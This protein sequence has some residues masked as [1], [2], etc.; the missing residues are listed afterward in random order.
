MLYRP[1]L[2]FAVVAVQQ[3][4]PNVVRSQIATGE[5]RWY[6][7]RCY[8]APNDTLTIES[9]VATIKERPWGAELLVEGDFNI[10]LS[11]PE[12]DRRGEDIAVALATE[13]L[14]DMS[15]HFLPRRRSWCRDGRM[16]SIIWE[17]REVRSCTDY[18]LGTD[19][20]IF[21]NVYVWDPQA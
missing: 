2:H 8:L 14:E 13:G 12:G 18:I 6:I 15:E 7:M 11:E 5:R 20:C 17:G 1:A 3:F 10:N 16:W 19:R 21:W 9:V 4:S